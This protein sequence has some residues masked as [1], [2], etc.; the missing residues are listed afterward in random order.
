M[1]GSENSQHSLAMEIQL[2]EALYCKFVEFGDE[3]MHRSSGS[4]LQDGKN[5]PLHPSIC[6]FFVGLI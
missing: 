3:R 2:F 5:S 6:V 1:V 4:V